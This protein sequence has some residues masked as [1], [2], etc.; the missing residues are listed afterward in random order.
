[1]T[2]EQN[3]WTDQG[4]HVTEVR[5]LDKSTGLKITRARSR[6]ASQ[7]KCF[8]ETGFHCNLTGI[9]EN[10]SSDPDALHPVQTSLGSA[11]LGRLQC[12]KEL[13][14]SS[15]E[16]L[17][18]VSSDEI[19]TSTYVKLMKR[20][21]AQTELKSTEELPLSLNSV[22]TNPFSWCL[23]KEVD[24]RATAL[25]Q[26]K[27]SFAKRSTSITC[28]LFC[29]L[30]QPALRKTSDQTNREGSSLEEHQEF[31]SHVATT[32]QVTIPL[33]KR[34]TGDSKQNSVTE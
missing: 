33:H 9:G 25:A 17:S 8:R 34:A 18:D 31:T 29:N 27:T 23:A 4:S 16:R 14:D 2:V 28:N 30:V 32:E 13:E 22:L 26:N 11:S 5:T 10:C 7:R 6:L 12:L 1:V 21:V 20:Q 15:N 3:I 24:E 19:H